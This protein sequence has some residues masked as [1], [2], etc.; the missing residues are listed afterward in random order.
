MKSNIK[1]KIMIRITAIVISSLVLISVF[2]YVYF[3]R[4]LENQSIRDNKIQMQMTMQQVDYIL[5]DIRQYSYNMIVD[6][7]VEQFLLKKVPKDNPDYVI[8]C[9]NIMNKLR[10]YISFRDYIQSIILKTQNG[11][12][13][14]DAL[15]D[16]YYSTL[17][18]EE[19]YRKASQNENSFSFSIPHEIK[20]WQPDYK[21]IS[22]I[23]HFRSIKGGDDL[24][25]E[26]IIN[27][28]YEHL[29]GILKKE[30]S[31]FNECIL[32]NNGDIIYIPDDNGKESTHT[33]DL[34]ELCRT[35]GKTGSDILKT[36]DG[37]LSVVR[38]EVDNWSFAV[39]TSKKLL[40][41]KFKNIFAYDFL[42]I[43]MIFILAVIVLTPVITNII[44]PVSR[45]L[46]AA[47]EVSRGNLNVNLNIRTGDEIE[48]LGTVFNDMTEKLQ[49]YIHKSIENEKI[50]HKMEQ[51]LLISQINPHFIYNTLNTVTYLARK[52]RDND[53]EKVIGSLIKILQDSLKISKREIFDTV[54]QEVDM[55]NQYT[56]IQK[57]RYGNTFKIVWEIQEDVRSWKIPKS[58]IQPLVENALFHGILPED[59]D[60]GIITVK[61]YL[62]EG[63]LTVKV[64]DNGVGM[65][66][67]IMDKLNNRE[68]IEDYVTD[69]PTGRKHIGIG[70]IKERVKNLYGADSQVWIDSRH[71]EGTCVTIRVK[72]FPPG[73]D[74]GM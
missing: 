20:G 14:T 65:S 32:T 21:V 31:Y 68:I 30:G 73:M 16:P 59:D 5:K 45:L 46:L 7:D 61:I 56:L 69:S 22:F 28:N 43:I 37:Y 10:K 27:I 1:S 66:R 54:S 29:A 11:V 34:L 50:K 44:R 70:N 2:S 4:I 40:F 58:I 25:G 71:D 19:W 62:E 8:S 24:N 15:F 63:Y 57:Y 51:D 42:Y 26:L 49:E 3:S 67:E 48:Q 53:V 47:Q 9:E 41:D 72:G 55:V 36:D 64:L 18:N 12:Y 52:N 74:E 23:I 33:V 60:N 6:T 13:S 38:S 17:F 35:A 39:Y